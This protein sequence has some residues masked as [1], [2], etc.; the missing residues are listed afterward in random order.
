LE[1]N[2]DNKMNQK[3]HNYYQWVPIVLMLQALANYLPVY[4]WKSWESQ[5]LH[6]YFK[7][8]KSGKGEGKDKGDE[9]EEEEAE[10]GNSKVNLIKLCKCLLVHRGQ[11]G[12]YGFLFVLSHFV[13]LISLVVQIHLANVFL[14]GFFVDYGMAVF[15]LQELQVPGTNITAA[16]PMEFVFPTVT[17][18]NMTY[19]SVIGRAQDLQGIC[20]LSLNIINQKIYVVIWVLYLAM[21]VW[22]ALSILG[23]FLLKFVPELRTAFVWAQMPRVSNHF[24]KVHLHTLSYSTVSLLGYFL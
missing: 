13:G 21:T 22:T 20:M 11:H 5:K 1:S 8:A 9:V 15:G 6:K 10:A 3:K 19:F 24:E 7:K 16:N 4:L 18:C 23:H 2:A 14:D 12:M 17:N